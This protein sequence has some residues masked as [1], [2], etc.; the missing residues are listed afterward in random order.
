MEGSKVDMTIS[1]TGKDIKVVA[2]AT[3]KNGKVYTERFTA[4]C[5]DANETLRAF[6]IVDGSYLVM[7]PAACY[8]GKPLY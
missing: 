8:I 6:L 7:D 1:R 5:S 4:P 2:V 3:C